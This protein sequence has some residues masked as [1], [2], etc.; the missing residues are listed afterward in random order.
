[1]SN[2]DLILMGLGNLFR[3]KMRTILTVLGVVIGTTSI[4]V[5]ISIGLGL[6]RKFEE[7]IKS[8]GSLTKISIHRGYR[9]DGAGTEV[10]FDDALVKRL[11][12]IDKVKVVVPFVRAQGDLF[13]G[14]V[15]GWANVVA[16]DF[17][18]LPNL[19]IVLSEGR[20]PKR[21]EVLVGKGVKETFWEYKAGNTKQIMV[22]PMKDVLEFK[23]RPKEWTEGVEKRKGMR[24][25]T[26][27]IMG[28][29]D[30]EIS[31]MIYVSIEDYEDFLQKYNKKYKVKK[32]SAKEKKNESK[33]SGIQVFAQDIDS[34]EP[35][36][37]TIKED[38]GLECY[39]Q[40]E[41]LNQ[42]KSQARMI[43]AILGG[44]GG[45]S[46]IVAAIGITNTMVMSIYER[47]KEIGIMKVIG[48]KVSDIRKLFLFEAAMIGFAG[49]VIGVG[50]SYGF[51]SVINSLAANENP[52]N[53]SI[54]SEFFS[55]SYLPIE[56]ALLGI[57]FAMMIGVLAGLYPSIRATKISAL[58]AIRTD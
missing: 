37:K 41:W 19:D 21:G 58:D 42:A 8:Y 29:D 13:F 47:T 26:S 43:Q 5:M 31:E 34:V 1:M 17:D 33:Y 49:G 45:V 32:P 9:G 54:V 23:I 18:L 56:L 51:S 6:D 12:Q 53:Y 46:L 44:V 28:N 14:K 55:Q 7:E 15:N 20:M 36:M 27:G 39:S 52:D 57:V 10:K 50:I 16:I 3:R 4:L 11:S 25:V 35:I 38:I 2:I 22:D 30:F 48:A 24:F 40:T